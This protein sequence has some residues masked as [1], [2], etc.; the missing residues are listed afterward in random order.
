[1]NPTSATHPIPRFLW[2]VII[3]LS[4]WFI[5]FGGIT[6]MTPLH[7]EGGYDVTH[8]KLKA[9][10]CA[11]ILGSFGLAAF[12][13]GHRPSLLLVILSFVTILGSTALM[14]FRCRT[15]RTFWTL[16]AVLTG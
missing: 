15:V 8:E 3:L 11:P 13:G 2:R 7:M 4:L 5:I 10:L 6:A 16:T 1:M 9:T 12:F 14:L